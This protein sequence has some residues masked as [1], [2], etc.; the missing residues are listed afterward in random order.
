MEAKLKEFIEALKEFAMES[1]AEIYIVGGYIRDRLLD[2]KIKPKDIDFVYSGPIYDLIKKMQNRGYRFYEVKE[3]AGIYGTVIS[4]LHID[5]SKMKGDSIQEDLLKRDFT[6][7]ANALN[8]VDMKIIDAFKGKRAIESR[9]LQEVSESSLKDDPIR[10]LRGMRF[11]IKY[12]FHF[13]LHTE[14]SVVKYA[15]MLKQCASQ[16]VF[17]ELMNIIQWDTNGSAFELLD[18]YH[19]L[20]NIIPYINELKA[21]G[22]CK[23]HLEDTFTHMNLTYKTFKEFMTGIIKIKNYNLCELDEI[24][25]N[26]SMKEYI[27]FSCFTQDIGKYFCYEEKGEMISFDNHEKAGAEIMEQKCRELK[28]PKEA[29][30]LVVCL[31]RNHMEPVELFKMRQ[32]CTFNKRL[33]DFFHLNS[34]YVP[35]ILIASYCDIYASMMI[36]DSW[37]EKNSFAQFVEELLIKFSKY[38]DI[39]RNK[40]IDGN[41]IMENTNSKGQEIGYIVNEV[42]QLIFSG[43]IKNKNESEEYILS[44][45]NKIY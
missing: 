31:I 14:E 37:D 16:R 11:Y 22:K 38:T 29:L 21:I 27:A 8:L 3:E 28:F 10:I 17:N 34:R 25:G 13:S 20:E 33:Y 30:K 1:E 6:I 45:Y 26:F 40:W 19:I 44:N 42:N 2:P 5:I 32:E 36:N 9:I 4:D 35:F 39:I 18:S 23:N 24:I 12:G 43:V 41:F 7:N 15:H